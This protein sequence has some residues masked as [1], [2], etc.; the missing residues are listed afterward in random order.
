MD[1]GQSST[2]VSLVGTA[3]RVPASDTISKTC[4]ACDNDGW[5]EVFDDEGFPVGVE[6]C[7]YLNRPFHAPFDATGLLGG[8]QS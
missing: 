5:V 2:G 6:E 7:P 8:D 1:H 3:S 4:P